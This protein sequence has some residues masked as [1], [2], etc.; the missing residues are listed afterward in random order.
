MSYFPAAGFRN[1]AAALLESLERLR[2]DVAAVVANTYPDAPQS[3]L[4]ASK[5]AATS[6]H[7][8]GLLEEALDHFMREQDPDLEAAHELES[9]RTR[10]RLL[11]ERVGVF[12]GLYPGF[13][14]EPSPTCEPPRNYR[15][16]LLEGEA[17]ALVQQYGETW[18]VTDNGGELRIDCLSQPDLHHGTVVVRELCL[19]ET[20]INDLGWRIRWSLGGFEVSG[21]AEWPN[22]L[23]PPEW[24]HEP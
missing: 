7:H 12:S 2:G 4:N 24:L 18:T 20:E 13:L 10:L 23:A 22:R 3:I 8:L 21:V 1:R 6:A 16:A 19:T 11:L 9:R 14:P 15:F 5:A 17:R